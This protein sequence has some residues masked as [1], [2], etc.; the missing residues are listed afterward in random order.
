MRNI[1]KFFNRFISRHMLVLMLGIAFSFPTIE[2]KAQTDCDILKDHGQGYTT[3]IS[4][5]TD[6]NDGTHT[7]VLNIKHNG[8]SGNCKAMSR[9][10]VEADPG[11]YS[12]VVI[13]VI[14]G[15][16]N[17]QNIDMGPDLGGDPF[18]GFRITSTAG[19]G[20]GVLGEFTITYTLSGGLQDQQTL[21]K[22]GNQLLIVSFSMEE[23]ESVMICQS[24]N[25]YPYYP[26]PEG[27]KLVN[28]LIGPD[29]TSLYYTY[30]ETGV[31]VSDNIFQIDSNKVLIKVFALPGEYANLLSILT[32]PTYGMT[33]V[34]G[35]PGLLSISGYYPIENL[36]MIDSLTDQ[37]N[38]ARPVYPPQS[39]RGIVTSQGDISLRSDI[40]R[41]AFN[42]EGAGVKIGVLSDSYN[43][44]L[45]DQA[46]DDVLRGDLP[47]TTNPY[48]S[49][50]VDVVL[51]Y[52]YAVRSDEGRAML[53]IIHDVAP[54]AELAF[55]TGFIN[56]E[57]FADG[58]VELQQA[59]CDIIVD[60]IT[61]ISEPFFRDGIV[62]RTVDS[63]S[64]LGV[65][66]FSAAG[67]YGS[68][69]YQNN[70]NPATPPAGLSGEAHNFAGTGGTDIYQSVSVPEGNY[71]MVLQWD[72][73]SP[74]GETN[75]DM[76]IYL[77]NDNGT[78]LFG[79]N[80]ENTGGDP[81]EVLPF[82]VGPGGA[83]TN[84]L[85]TRSAGTAPVNLKYIVFRGA[86]SMNEYGNTGTS[87]ITG[88]ANA[89]STISIGA[90]LFSNTPA[91]GVDPPTIASFSSR[92]G[93]AVDGIVRMKPD[94]TAPNGV[95]TTVDLGGVNIDGDQFPNFFGT[96]AAAPHAAA[97]AG[98]I[99]EAGQKFYD[100]DL[101][102]EAMRGILESSALDMETPG[103]D[104]S[105]G[106]GFIRADAALLSL[107][108]PSPVISDLIYD[109]TLI[110]GED[111]LYFTVVGN[112]LTEG[113][114]I[115]FNGQVLDS[116][117]TVLGDTAI[118]GSIYP[119]TE[120]YPAI[121]VY[122]PPNPQTNGS[123]G[124]LSNPLYFNDKETVL[125][126]I[127][128]TSKQYGETIPEFSADYYL[129][130]TEG[131]T[132]LDSSDLT[133]EEINRIRAIPL[134]TVADALSN[135]G[136]WEIVPSPEDPLNPESNLTVSTSLDSTLVEN[137]NFVFENGLMRI[138][139]TDLKIVPNDTCFV[140]GDSVKDVSFHY[141]FN[142]DPGNQLNI[143]PEDSLAMLSGLYFGHATALVNGKATALV[144]A[145][146]LLDENGDPLLDSVALVN[147]SFLISE[148]TAN[149]YATALVNGSF[150]NPSSL[151][152]ATALVNG[153]AVALV[154][155]A[156]MVPA[157]AL[158]NGQA[159]VLVNG[160][161][162]ALVN[163]EALVNATALVNAGTIN[164]TSNSETIVILGEQ[165]I[166]ILSGDSSG[167]ITLR[168]INMI[169]GNEVGEHLFLP[170]AFVSNNF[171]VSYGFG[172]ICFLPDTAEIAFNTADLI[173]TYSGQ[174]AVVSASTTPDSLN[175][176]LTYDGDSSA[177]VDAGIY[178]VTATVD[179]PNYVGTQIDT[180]EIL[181]A[182]AQVIAGTD[183]IF[184][185]DP[186]PALTFTYEGFVNGENDSVVHTYSYTLSPNYNNQAGTYTVIPTA[187]AD[188]YIF[189]P[190]NGTLYV[191][192]SG[193]G[194]KHLIPK[195]V[196][197]DEVLPDSNGFTFVATF[198][199]NNNNN[200]V[201]YI[202][203]GP[204]NLLS[205]SGSFNNAEQ[206]EAFMPGGGT[207]Q[208]PFD[209]T[210]L[211]WTLASYNHKGQKTS[212]GATANSGSNSCNKNAEAL[213][214]DTGEDDKSGITAFPNPFNDR[215]YLALNGHS[216][217]YDDLMVFDMM[218]NATQIGIKNT[219]SGTI[220]LD[221]SAA[222]AGIYLLRIRLADKYEIL[223]IVKQ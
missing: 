189:S 184:E 166:A 173:Q 54:K 31:A 194:T 138:G 193:P 7:I 40:A 215:V 223:R 84:I 98:L 53:Q 38:Y 22:A 186:L 144:N 28:S 122:N 57:D 30:L 32:S 110:P 67:N 97:V 134:V 218:G 6:N 200:D 86:L 99:K 202:P 105:S 14:S 176:G 103:Y 88:Q 26:P 113:S 221:L 111:T 45:G 51:D 1:Y 182:S 29:L 169:T 124:G 89:E 130:N 190:V 68:K 116:G 137:Y 170:G 212:Q 24:S 81:I 162:T 107:A 75:T 17:Y 161:A 79:F 195:L 83:E 42:L 192:P 199:Y 82:T 56:P 46:A 23:F 204:D 117:T 109:T 153:Q 18:Q 155:G 121:Q 55:R 154:N 72:D 131:S 145:G 8:C 129:V 100:A 219:G 191:N 21:V 62:A 197:V 120:L 205:S 90:V 180:L 34:K 140:Y 74:T 171:N 65:A 217:E 164:D 49:I 71:I 178:E 60:D 94:F 159:A 112:Y 210:D 47:G 118:S 10:S 158:V 44:Q 15:S 156:A 3:A 119:F 92:G 174:P 133:Q 115:Y 12:D 19:F 132:L 125:V 50:P 142:N 143:L 96:S 146:D 152:F 58:I 16:L 211:T 95:N 141:I 147:T 168:S 33:E 213:A 13:E 198:E 181:P 139:K 157:T 61:Y 160:Q 85:I 5:V 2:L 91:Y 77:A 209:G 101:S 9:Y 151:L 104:F 27:G 39:N 188:N 150:I 87:T 59:G 216:L 11:T 220:E 175:L 136:L 52:P 25:I 183:F 36:L 102:P 128:D 76:D 48:N 43:T 206:P 222:K 167:F 80:R 177:P 37:V 123:D 106:H 93:T 203:V 114:Q 163:N 69:S 148:A 172:N 4:S 64:A 196:C 214:P 108:N 135:A 127:S 70:F 126:S 63:I 207:F 66:Y 149:A 73:G 201:V 41:N 78:T 185:G 35:V 187:T 179:D 208:I 165:D 20:N